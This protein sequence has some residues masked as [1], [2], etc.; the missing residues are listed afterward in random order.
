V[1][2]A[3]NAGQLDLLGSSCLLLARTISDADRGERRTLAV[4]V[5]ELAGV[6]RAL[7]RAPGDR[8]TRQAAADR[9]LAAARQLGDGGPAQDVAGGSTSVARYAVRAVA[10]D[11]MVFAGVDSG[12]AARAVETVETVR[13]DRPRLE[14]PDPPSTPRLPFSSR[15]RR[16]RPGRHG[17]GQ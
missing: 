5:A 9:A 2:E 13:Q 16:H 12:T 14:V 17:P 8:D 10:T 6:L 1:R 11:A 4:H 7:A 15:P 3:E